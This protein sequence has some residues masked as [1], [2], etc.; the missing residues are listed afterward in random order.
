MTPREATAAATADN[1]TGFRDAAAAENKQAQVHRSAFVEDIFDH[2]LPELTEATVLD[3]FAGVGTTLVEAQL[4]G[5]K[6]VGFE[7]NAYAALACRAKLGAALVDPDDFSDVITNYRYEVG[8]IEEAVDVG[9]LDH[10]QPRSS[11][12]EGFSTRIPFYSPPVLT[13]VLFTHD[14]IAD[15]SDPVMRDLMRLAFASVMVS[16]SNYTY[17]PSLCDSLLCSTRPAT[18]SKNPP[19]RPPGGTALPT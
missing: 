19:R 6:A 17:E 16:F 5:W 13:K 2:Y 1:T 8:E 3:P 14:Y 11:P 4:R 9:T 12:P 7:I 18:A 10:R 15:V